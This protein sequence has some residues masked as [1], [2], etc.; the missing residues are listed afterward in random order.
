MEEY[1][2][3]LKAI[4]YNLYMLRSPISTEDL[5]TQALAGLDA[6]YNPIVVQQTEKTGLTWMDLLATLLTYENHLEQLNAISNLS[7]N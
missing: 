7:L 3:K 2:N 4:S 6:D 1:L 5:I